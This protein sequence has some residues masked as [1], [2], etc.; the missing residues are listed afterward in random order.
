[1]LYPFFTLDQILDPPFHRLFFK[2]IASIQIDYIF[3]TI[4][5]AKYNSI[6]VSLSCNDEVL[7]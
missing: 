7:V 2:S 3:R 6:F 1:L 5:K 4:L